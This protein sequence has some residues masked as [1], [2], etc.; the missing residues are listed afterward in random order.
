MLGMMAALR[1]RSDR[2]GLSWGPPGWAGRQRST[3]TLKHAPTAVPVESSTRPTTL[4][5]VLL[6]GTWNRPSRSTRI[7][8]AEATQSAEDKSQGNCT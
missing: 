8:S 6:I 7:Y 3:L 4:M 2:C 1:R 5:L